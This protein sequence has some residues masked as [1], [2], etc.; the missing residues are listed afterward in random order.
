MEIPAREDHRSVR[1]NTAARSSLRHS[2]AD[3][4]ERQQGWGASL[5]PTVLKR[6]TGIIAPKS[7]T[8]FQTEDP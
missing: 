4:L 8:S 3:G 7:M 1:L 6:D 5:K 2:S